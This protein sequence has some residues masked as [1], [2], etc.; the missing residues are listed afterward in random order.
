MPIPTIAI[1][2][3]PNV[4]KSTLFN[5]IL[6]KKLAVVEDTPGV[7]R[8]RNYA[9]AEF[10]GRR[11]NLVDTGGFE[12]VTVDTLLTQMR[13]QTAL[14]IEEADVI[15]MMMDA[16]EGLNV[17]DMKVSELLRRSGK[18]VIYCVNK[19]DGP[20]QEEEV[21]DFFR[22]GADEV[23]SVSALHGP[24]FY[25]LMEKIMAALPEESGEDAAEDVFA[26]VA[27]IGRPNV[28]KSSLLNALTS[29]NRV[30]V[31][32]MP[33]TT[34]DT[35]DTEVKYYG[36]TYNLIDTAG[37]RSRGKIARGVEKYSVVRALKAIDRCD[38]ALLMIDAHE[39]LTE[40]D[41]KIGGLAHEEGKGVIIVLNKW[42]LVDKETGVTEEYVKKIRLGLKFLDYAPVVTISALT[43]QRIGKLYELIDTVVEE[44]AKRIPTPKVNDVLESAVRVH[45]PGL[46]HNRRIKFYFGVQGGIKPPTFILFVNRP[47][48]VHFSY[49]RYLE[50]RFREVYGFIGNPVRIF[51][52]KRSRVDL[53]ETGEARRGE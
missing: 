43:R 34:T 8:D 19:V 4:G 50:N 36:K 15:V 51:L 23:V 44:G 49:L 47:E 45:P 6:H 37:I 7:T 2:G 30:V 25:E 16:R 53:D 13:E 31:H 18:P 26:N 39:G 24:G 35:I 46:H 3:R 21:Y 20:K 10:D 12:P 11:F 1:V 48:G 29:S 28:G 38:L 27:I 52:K 5:R 22:L 32:D 17:S 41:K 40:Q 14:A 33:G 42:D 9:V